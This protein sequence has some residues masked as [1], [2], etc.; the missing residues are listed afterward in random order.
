MIDYGDDTSSI[1]QISDENYCLDNLIY[2]IFIKFKHSKIVL[3][4]YMVPIL[5][6]EITTKHFPCFCLKILEKYY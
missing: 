3:I 2:K 6:S 1:D 5:S 4:N